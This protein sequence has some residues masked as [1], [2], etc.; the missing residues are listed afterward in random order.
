MEELSRADRG[1]IFYGEN[2]SLDTGG[3]NYKVYDLAGKL[4]KEV[5]SLEAMQIFRAVI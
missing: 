4:I 5:K 1:I 2:G 3:D